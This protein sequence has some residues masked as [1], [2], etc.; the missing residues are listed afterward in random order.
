MGLRAGHRRARLGAPGHRCGRFF[1]RAL[2]TLKVT[3]AEGDHR[4]PPVI[5]GMRDEQV[6]SAWHHVERYAN[7]PIEADHSQLRRRL[8]PMRGLRTDRT[9]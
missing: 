8:K 9:A 3:P 4:R 7:N 2:V 5:P 1:Q 6:P